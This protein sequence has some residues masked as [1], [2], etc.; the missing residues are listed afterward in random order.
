MDE[1]ICKEFC[2]QTGISGIAQSLSTTRLFCFYNEWLSSQKVGAQALQEIPVS[3][4]RQM[5]AEAKTL[6]AARMLEMEPK[7]QCSLAIALLA[8]Q[9]TTAMNDI[10]VNN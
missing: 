8:V 4:A 9:S 10:G 3:K 7:K 1:P 6:D 5:A 2:F